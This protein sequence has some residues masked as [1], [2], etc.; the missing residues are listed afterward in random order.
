MQQNITRKLCQKYDMPIDDI[1][2]SM[3]ILVKEHYIKR[4][5]Y[6]CSRLGLIILNEIR[7]Q[8]N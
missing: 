8:Y 6:V 1:I 3:S 7:V 4:Y 2:I 5:E